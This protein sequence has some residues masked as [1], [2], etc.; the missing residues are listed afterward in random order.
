MRGPKLSPAEWWARPTLRTKTQSFCMA[1]GIARTKG[2][3]RVVH[4]AS[5]LIVISGVAA[6]LLIAGGV[7][8]AAQLIGTA[9]TRYPTGYSEAALRQVQIGHGRETVLSLLGEPLLVSRPVESWQYYQF[10]GVVHLVLNSSTA[11]RPDLMIVQSVLHCDGDGTWSSI[12]DDKW[13]TV[14]G[15]SAAGVEDALGCPSLVTSYRDQ[16]EIWRYSTN[17]ASPWYTC[18]EVVFDMDSG[19]VVDKLKRLASD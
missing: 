8:Q 19:L 18:V 17:G 12:D 2:Q 3:S 11:T 15:L 14:V 6:W 9:V 7:R 10:D 16:P 1:N 4:C 13:S 5:L